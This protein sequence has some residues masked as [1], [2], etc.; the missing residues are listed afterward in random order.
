MKF[1]PTLDK[2][3]L[4]ETIQQVYGYPVSDLT[5]V[6]EGMVGCHY[7]ADC[8]DGKRTFVTLLTGSYLATLQSRRLDF[9][10]ALTSRLHE[11]GL[12]SAQPA[13]CRTLDGRLKAKFQGQPLII[14]EY[15][16]G[17]N[18][19]EV[20]P[21]PPEVLTGLGRLTAQLHR[22]TAD[23]GMNVPY[24]EQFR[25]PFE[26]PL[27]ASLAGLEQVPDDARPGKVEL[28]E[29]ILPRRKTILGLLARL[30]E[31]GATS[32]ALN[33]PLVLVHSDMTP[34]NLLRTPQGDLFIV[35]WEGVM[36]APAEHDLFIFAGEGFTTLLAEYY[37]LAGKPRLHP[38]LFAYYFYRRNLE[39]ITD[40]IIRIL[41]ENT[42]AE[43]DRFELDLLTSNCLSSWPFL[44]KSL[45]W[46]A[47]Q[48]RA[49][50]G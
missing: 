23:I 35:D 27:L 20:W 30:H 4:M 38:E 24:V 40:F 15:I 6:P 47:E 41:R 1:E 42:T 26:E 18:L 32:R 22:A 39:D 19:G 48:I 5:F 11:R 7:I 44:E 43:E 21:Y 31:L 33:P 25:L 2:P 29:F 28:R 16:E 17:G 46:A 13:V 8:T 37:R 10:L 9:T 49:A 45:G 12:F 50:A 34:N 14:Y 36:L 3:A